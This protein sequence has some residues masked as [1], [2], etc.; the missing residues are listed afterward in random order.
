M[1]NIT[2]QTSLPS[3]IVQ[4]VLNEVERATTLHR[5]PEDIIHAAAIVAEESGELIREAVNIEY[6]YGDRDKA[7]KE[8][9]QT[10]AVCFRFLL[11][12]AEGTYM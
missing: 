5:W 1:Q 6:E 11:G 12:L 7:Q 3:T 4:A 2:V 9:I 8:A 10:A